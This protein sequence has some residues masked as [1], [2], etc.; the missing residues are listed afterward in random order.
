MECLTNIM[1]SVL[2]KI[3]YA[4]AV[5]TGTALLACGG[6]LPYPGLSVEEVYSL[7]VGA[8]EEENWTEATKAFE[9]VLLSAGFDRMPEAGL[10][11]AESHFGN[12]RFIAARTEFQRVID[13]W[14]TD[15]TTV[16][17]ALG[18][19]RSL[20]EMSPIPQRDQ[21]FT[22]QAQITCGQVA[23]QFAGT[24]IGLRASEFSDEMVDKLA[25]RD[26]NTGSHYL[27]RGLVDSSLLYYEEVVESFPGSKWAPW[28]LYR[29]IEAFEMIGYVRDAETTRELLL[30]SYPESEPAQM[31]E[32]GGK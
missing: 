24:V 21:T 3:R 26:Y 17:A 27:K 16:L 13:R 4:L 25:E 11:L 12:G 19:C 8:L 18:V 30:G 20:T 23:A 31:L 1:K 6:G 2:R 5:T 32:N 9:E 14:P 15:T 28:A 10:Q 29:M 22:R 7:G